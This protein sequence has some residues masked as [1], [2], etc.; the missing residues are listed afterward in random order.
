MG[1][2][3]SHVHGMNTQPEFEAY[4]RLLNQRGVNLGKLP[5]SP[6][7]ATGQRWLH[8]WNTREQAESFAD[9]LNRR[10]RNNNWSVVE[11]DAVPSEGPLGPVIIQVGRRAEGW[12]LGVHPLSRAMIHSGFEGAKQTLTRVTIDSE[13]LQDFLTTQGDPEEL[14]HEVLLG[15]TGLS[16]TDLD[17]LG[18][19]LIDDESNRSLVF[20]PPRELTP[21]ADHSSVI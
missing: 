10:V 12:V 13:K 3:V 4:A 11:V 20:V 7:P 14:A 21:V 5:R 19:T 6:D 1:F 15:L 9:E 17:S 2:T 18:Y 16:A 8:V